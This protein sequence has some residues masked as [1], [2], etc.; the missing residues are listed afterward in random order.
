MTEG[1][2]GE[3]KGGV[4]VFGERMLMVELAAFVSWN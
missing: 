3:E 2:L 4:S 1:P